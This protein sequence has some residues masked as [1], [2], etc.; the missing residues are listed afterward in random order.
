ME[1]NEFLLTKVKLGE[2]DGIPDKK[3]KLQ[4]ILFDFQKDIVRWACRK[5]RAAIF[6]DCGLG[7]SFMQISWAYNVAKHT[8]GKVIIFAPL[9]VNPQTIQE[10]QKLGIEV[11]RFDDD[12]DT[13]IHIAN[14]EN[15]EN[16]NPNDYT[17]IVLDESSILKSVNSKTRLKI[18]DFC[19]NIEFRL[20]CTATPAPN[21]ISEISN[22]TQYLGVMKR[23]EMLSRW[24]YNN[25][26]NWNLK[27]HAVEKFWKWVTSWGIFISKPSDLGYL[28]DGYALPKLNIDQIIF[29]FEMK[30]DGTLFD[31]GLGGIE[32]RIKIRS[33]TIETKAQEIADMVNK[34][35]EQWIVWCGINKEAESMLKLVN[36]SVNVEGSD[37]P[38]VKFEKIMNFKEGKTKVLITKPK[39]A[40]FG[41]NFQNANNMVF[42]GIGDSYEA[43]YQCIRRCYRFGQEK[44]VNV[45]IAL[46][47]N[48]QEI[49]QNVLRKE[50]NAKNLMMNIIKQ[51]K[52][53][54]IKELKGMKH[55]VMNYERNL[56]EKGNYKAYLGDSC[57]VLREIEDESIDFSV[58]SPP[59]SSLYTYSNSERDL[60]NCASDDE[61]LT[62]FKFIVDELLRVVKAGRLVAVHCMNLPTKKIVDGFIGIKDFRG[63]LI[64]LFQKSGFIYHSEVTIDKNPQIAAIR[65]K[66]RGLMFVQMEK[67]SSESR[68]GLA[69]YIVTFKKPGK[70]TEPVKNDLTRDEWITFAHPVWYDI[71]E[72]GTLQSQK[73]DKDEK[74][75]CPLQL[76]VIERC[77]RLWSNKGDTV[78]SPFMGIGSEGYVS[79]Q[80]ERKFIGVELKNDY[81]KQALKNL[82]L[83]DHKSRN[84]TLLDLI[85]SA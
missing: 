68:M 10:G 44:E 63:D 29:D 1:L 16:V 36:E 38:N 11:S 14:Y 25:G 80:H 51:V 55:E 52:E 56:V 6:A 2:T 50:R 4:S 83:A 45:K 70:S 31:V 66:A 59:F 79:L 48:E 37:S 61:F 19:K 9:S 27:G 26:K 57:E 21:D 78:L 30:H 17:G 47:G 41:M 22:H 18:F 71:K 58:F 82:D 77:V 46:A 75:I 7:K 60:G 84:N 8:K 33:Q 85:E 5:G 12:S 62:H 24:F 74:H 65:T 49:F 35:D 76:E 23:E 28:D 73:F 81:F 64:R 20:A 54:G 15:I 32:D 3:I 43:Y 13:V 42:F 67:D 39:I 53:E 34:S 72:T 69:D 40:G